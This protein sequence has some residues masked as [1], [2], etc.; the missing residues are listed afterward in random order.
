VRFWLLLG[1][2]PLICLTPDILLKIHQKVFKPTPIDKVLLSA[3]TKK[4]QITYAEADF[5][6]TLQNNQVI[7][8]SPRG[9]DT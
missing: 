5:D 7:N 6:F 2:T 1:I 8:V 3:K 9:D 4:A